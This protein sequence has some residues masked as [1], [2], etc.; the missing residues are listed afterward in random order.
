MIAY[1]DNSLTDNLCRNLDKCDNLELL[2]EMSREILSCYDL[3]KI[4][5]SLYAN[6]NKL[7]DAP[8]FALAVHNAE[9]RCLEFWGVNDSRE[10]LR[11]GKISTG[12]T[13]VWS[14]HCFSNQKELIFNS[15]PQDTT[16]HFSRLL[17]DFP[18]TKRQ[19]FI[20]LPLIAKDTCVGLITVQSFCENAYSAKQVNIF[21]SLANF[22]A[23]SVENA[24]AFRKIEEQKS[25]IIAKTN[26]LESMMGNMEEIISLRTEQIAVQ[27]EELSIK[28]H[29]L[30]EANK[31]LE[32]LSIVAKET[33]NAIMIMDAE[34][35]IIWINDFFTML[36]GYSYTDFIARRGNNILQ[37]SFN[38]DIAEILRTC[39]ETRC[40]QFYQAANVLN[41]GES[42]WAQTTLTPVLDDAGQITHLVS[43]DSDITKIIEAEQFITKQAGNIRDSIRYASQ[44]QRAILPSRQMMGGLFPDYFILYEPRDIVSGDFYWYFDSGEWTWVVAADCTGHGVPAALMSI[45]GISLLQEIS[46]RTNIATAADILCS[47]RL[48]LKDTIRQRDNHSLV[49]DGMD[50]SLC[51]LKKDR[52]QLQFAGAYNPIIVVRENEI[53][54]IKA[55]KMPIG[56]HTLEC[57]HFTNRIMPLVPGDR[58]YMYSDGFASQFGGPDNK[59]FMRRNLNNLLLQHAQLPMA[60]Q[61]N[62]LKSKLRCWMSCHDT[63]QTDDILVLGFGI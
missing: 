26:I 40:P 60:E 57:N 47:L 22:I 12:R 18:D 16:K 19:S 7:L 24:Q 17:F 46:R 42:V 44:I 3:M 33:N 48:M 29:K 43:I 6:I 41:S 11:M 31:E 2:F 39:I 21:R 61:K 4:T 62:L 30:A 38:P 63:E 56:S 9:E 25:E 8:I 55:D 13:D 54:E 35:N 1:H 59:K 32:L 51:M 23:L 49:N 28:T 52:S 34:G 27:K 36:Y 10:A 58:I 5:H 15:F 45:L 53:I 14:V 20:Y 37:T 50:I